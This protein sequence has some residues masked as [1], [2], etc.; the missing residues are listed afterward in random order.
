ML[1]PHPREYS[2]LNPRPQDPTQDS[3]APASSSATSSH[4]TARPTLS[5]SITNLI[6]TPKTLTLDVK[7]A[8][9]QSQSRGGLYDSSQPNPDPSMHVFNFYLSTIQPLYFVACN[10]SEEVTRDAA[11][12]LLE[13]PKRREGAWD[14][15]AMARI[16]RRR[17]RDGEVDGK[18]HRWL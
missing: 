4:D 18:G 14:S 9:L 3:P 5:P 7:L 1:A 12:Q 15:A 13:T 16:A 6:S 2:R 8:R 10:C 11:L 17:I